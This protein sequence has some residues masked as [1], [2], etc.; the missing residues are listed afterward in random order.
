MVWLTR[1]ES[2]NIQCQGQNI[3]QCTKSVELPVHVFVSLLSA[4]Y[5]IIKGNTWDMTTLSSF[6]II[7]PV[8]RLFTAGPKNNYLMLNY[9]GCL[10]NMFYNFRA[11]YV[12]NYLLGAKYCAD[13]HHFQRISPNY[14]DDSLN[15]NLVT[16][17]CQISSWTNSVVHG[18]L[19]QKLMNIT[20]IIVPF[21]QCQNLPDK[22]L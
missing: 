4:E 20:S 6:H 14:C 21:D 15:F 17:P 18:K 3:S 13:F 2:L 7:P 1:L 19:S 22:L 9:V 16:P 10:S 5:R 11:K 8:C 12:E